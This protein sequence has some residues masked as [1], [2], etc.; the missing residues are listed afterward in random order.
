[1]TDKINYR[2]EGKY[3]NS[4][5]QPWYFHSDKGGFSSTF[6]LNFSINNALVDILPVNFS[7]LSTL[8]IDALTNEYIEWYLKRQGIIF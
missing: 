6:I 2:F 8:K 5:K 1:M 4:Y 3:P 7:G